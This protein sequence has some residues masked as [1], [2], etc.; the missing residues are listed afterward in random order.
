MTLFFKRLSGPS[1]AATQVLIDYINEVLGPLDENGVS[2]RIH[3][4]GNRSYGRFHG[5]DRIIQ[6]LSYSGHDR[7]LERLTATRPSG[8]GVLALASYLARPFVTVSAP[9]FRGNTELFRQTVR[10]VQERAGYSNETEI[11]L[12]SRLVFWG[13]S[14]SRHANVMG[15]HVPNARHNFQIASLTGIPNKDFLF[16][17]NNYKHVEVSS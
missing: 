12:A 15:T 13:K 11:D 14:N 16:M 17:T 5:W 10:E 4:L 8:E 9:G 6:G 3:Y 1:T 2:A 7:E